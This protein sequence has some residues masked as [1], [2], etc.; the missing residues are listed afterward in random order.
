MAGSA[1][2]NLSSV[3]ASPSVSTPSKRRHQETAPQAR[4]RA[5]GA[6]QGLLGR[7]RPGLISGGTQ[8]ASRQFAGALTVF[9]GRHTVDDDGLRQIP[10]N[11]SSAIAP[12]WPLS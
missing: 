8:H 12:Q 9:E 1:A 11:G 10:R 6:A 7:D 4:E 5:R 2:R 3:S